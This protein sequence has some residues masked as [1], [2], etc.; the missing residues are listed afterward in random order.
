MCFF[1]GNEKLMKFLLLV[2]LINRAAI[3]Y[4]VNCMFIGFDF[5]R[6]IKQ[7]HNYQNC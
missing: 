1:G 2:K 3:V 6:I 4:Q 7:K 5:R